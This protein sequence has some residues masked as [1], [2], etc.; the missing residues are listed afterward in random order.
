MS[1]AVCTKF[2]C[3]ERQGSA[4][5]MQRRSG[6]SLVELLVAITIITAIGAVLLPALQS[7]R[8][9]ARLTSCRNNMSQLSKGMI[10]HE[11]FHGY[12]PS[13]G[14]SPQWL[15]VADRQGDSSQP[16]GWAF[17]VL[18]YIEELSTRNLVAKIP[19][20]GESAAY[21]KLLTASLPTFTCSSRRG[22]RSLPLSNTS[23][24]GGAVTLSRASRSDY[25][26]NG[27]SGGSAAAGFEG[28]CPRLSAYA[29][30]ISAASKKS[31]S[32]KVTICHAPPGNP[33]KGNT[34]NISVSGLNGHQNHAGDK[35]GACDSCDDPVDTILSSPASLEE[36]DTWRRMSLAEKLTNLSDMG[37][38]DVIQDGMG[39]RMTRLQAASVYDGLSNTY[40]IGEKYVASNTYGSGADQ[41]DSAPMMAGYSSNNSR[42]GIARPARDARGVSNP[43]A[44]GSGHVGG[45]NAAYADGMV[46]TV[47]FDID[48][49]LHVQLSSRNDGKGMPPQ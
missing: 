42:W 45:W 35:L 25:A 30:A 37:I 12:F 4:M 28:L 31:G 36:G 49:T 20:G 1:V 23:F 15:G 3:H 33:T 24:Q 16:G 27:G 48:P 9:A 41:G 14:W 2:L 10:Q 38:P 5:R 46:R 13:G 19:A 40:L 21:T 34:L 11:T 7:A 43:R 39:G 8:E 32:K 44:F 26:V 17:G 47:S 18:P 22:S 6:F 29:S